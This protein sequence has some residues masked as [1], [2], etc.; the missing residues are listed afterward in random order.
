MELDPV[1]NGLLFAGAPET[2]E[3]TKFHTFPAKLAREL[4]R[5][6]HCCWEQPLTAP[7]ISESPMNPP[8]ASPQL[9]FVSS[10]PP[11]TF[12]RRK[13]APWETPHCRVSPD[14]AV[15]AMFSRE[16]QKLVVTFPLPSVVLTVR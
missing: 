2:P 7:V 16:R 15:I 13:S 8:L 10:S 1:A 11:F 14:G 9:V 12:T 4:L 5:V 6:Y 3:K